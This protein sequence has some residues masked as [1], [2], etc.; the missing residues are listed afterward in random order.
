MSKKTKNIAIRFN[1]EA[2]VCYKNKQHRDAVLL[3]TKAIELAPDISHF[4]GNRAQALYQLKRFQEAVDD[5]LKAVELDPA[6]WKG[7]VRVG[8]CFLRLGLLAEARECFAKTIAAFAQCTE[9]VSVAQLELEKLEV[10]EAQQREVQT[11][12]D[13]EDY[14]NCALGLEKLIDV[15]SHNVEVHLMLADAYCHLGR[16]DATVSLV[17]RTRQR[18]LLAGGEQ[19]RLLVIE[20]RALGALTAGRWGLQ[21]RVKSHWVQPWSSGSEGPSLYECLGVATSASQDDIVTAYTDIASHC[22]PERQPQSIEQAELDEVTARYLDATIAFTMLSDAELRELYDLGVS[23][24]AILSEDIDPY[25]LFC[26]L[27]PEGAA[28]SSGTVCA[29]GCVGLTCTPLVSI[30][31]GA[32]WLAHLTKMK[33]SGSGEGLS[34]QEQRVGLLQRQRKEMLQAARE[35]KNRSET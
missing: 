20:M 12:Y 29:H 35:R 33:F 15:V 32:C 6:F 5:S 34:W 30:A 21:D 17:E 2:N 31:S 28:S 18:F 1:N 4:Y 27:P 13:C 7:Q 3:Y 25:V 19:H 10:A 16:Y 9:A 24:R 11:Q 23:P 8:K 26:G 22:H 14:G